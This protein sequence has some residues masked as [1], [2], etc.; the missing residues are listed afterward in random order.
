M[1]S[2]SVRRVQKVRSPVSVAP[3]RSLPRPERLTR[4]PRPRLTVRPPFL[5]QELKDVH[6][7]ADLKDLT[8]EPEEDN[9]LRWNVVMAGPVRR[10]SS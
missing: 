4:A 9:L 2:T 6:A 8:V 3:A 7:A 10:P 1:A 5:L